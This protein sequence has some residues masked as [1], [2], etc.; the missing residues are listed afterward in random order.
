ML[1]H[2][3]D[4][5]RIICGQ[6]T[7]ALELLEE[8]PDL[9]AVLTPVGGGGLLSGTLIAAKGVNPRIRVVA[10]EPERADDAY[11]SWK[12]GRIEGLDKAD[13]VADGLRTCLG[14][15]TFAVIQKLVDEIVLTSEESILGALFLVLERA[16]IVVEPSAV[17]PVAVL[18]EE[19]KLP[20]LEGKRV[21][22]ILSGGNLDFSRLAEWRAEN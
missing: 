5:W 15:R 14:E 4:D 21:G 22:V 6:G 3:Y 18:L 16:K 1:V 11:R 2:P 13:T 12:S 19:G 7:A 9:D 17:V 8:V 10:G 20:Q